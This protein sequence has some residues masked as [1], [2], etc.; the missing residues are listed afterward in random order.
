LEKKVAA[1]TDLPVRKMVPRKPPSGSV[2]K[3]AVGSLLL[4][5]ARKAEILPCPGLPS[6]RLR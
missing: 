5:S 3:V 2:R 6:S 1:T 4:P